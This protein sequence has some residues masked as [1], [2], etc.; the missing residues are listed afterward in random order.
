MTDN[1]NHTLATTIS[2]ILNIAEE[3]K[4]FD[5]D[6]LLLGEEAALDK[7]SPGWREDEWLDN[8]GEDDEED[9]KDSSPQSKD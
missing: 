8:W 7:H 3:G 4:T 9:S 5:R 2:D 1:Q 6:V